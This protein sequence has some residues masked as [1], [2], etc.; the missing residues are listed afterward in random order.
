VRRGGGARLA[1]ILVTH[2]H[3]DHVGSVAALSRR[4][5]LEVRGH[6][7][8]LARL[9]GEWRRGAPLAD[10]DELALGTAPDGS[11]GWKLRAL[12]TPGHDRGHLA[13]L[14]S[15]YGALLAGD[16]VSTL[17]TIVIDPPEGHMATYLASLARCLEEP[18][19]AVHPAHGMARLD[20]RAVLRRYLEHRRARE[21]QLVA[22]LGRG[23]RAAAEL[24]PEVYA[25]VVAELLPLA[26]R[27]LAAGLEKLAEEGRAREDGGRW[28]L[29]AGQRPEP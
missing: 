3:Q 2:H 19:G 18:L 5:D 13:F 29:V 12:H 23:P 24:L 8:T 22:A 17:S 21:A 1:G 7:L 27:S 28:R 6:A 10:E 14:E 16:L 20:G 9:P 11:P 25:D 4:Y 15:R 26:A